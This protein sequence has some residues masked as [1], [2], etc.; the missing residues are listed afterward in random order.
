[1]RTL[2]PRI[3]LREFL[4]PRWTRGERNLAS[5]RA[6][7]GGSLTRNAEARLLN[8]PLS[9]LLR[10]ATPTRLRKSMAEE[11][12]V[13]VSIFSM[14]SAY[15]K[16]IYTASYLWVTTYQSITFRRGGL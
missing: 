13:G 3:G 15:G 5:S 8:G 11:G 16:K 6:L 14:L 12:T 4:C 2:K 10:P 1:M 9:F 7:F